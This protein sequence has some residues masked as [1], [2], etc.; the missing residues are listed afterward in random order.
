MK[1]KKNRKKGTI[2]MV[3][4]AVACIKYNIKVNHKE[5]RVEWLAVI[6]WLACST[7]GYKALCCVEGRQS[8]D[9]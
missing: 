4:A 8:V 3:Q 2:W 7:Y 5:T 6:K 9:M 1:A